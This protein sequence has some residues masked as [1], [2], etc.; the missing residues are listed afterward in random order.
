MESISIPISVLQELNSY[1]SNDNNCCFE[2]TCILLYYHHSPLSTRWSNTNATSANDHYCDNHSNQ[3]SL[4]IILYNIIPF[5]EDKADSSNSIKSRTF[6]NTQQQQGEVVEDLPVVQLHPLLEEFMIVS[7]NNINHKNHTVQNNA[8]PSSSSSQSSKAIPVSLQFIHPPN[9]YKCHYDHDEI[10][11]NNNNNYDDDDELLNC[12]ISKQ[13]FYVQSVPSTSIHNLTTA[14]SA[15][16]DNGAIIYNI[17]MILEFIYCSNELYEQYFI[18]MG[19]MSMMSTNMND[20]YHWKNQENEQRM[21][22]TTQN[23]KMFQ[24]LYQILCQAF[25]YRIVKEEMIVP[26]ILPPFP[27]NLGS[28]ID[29]HNEEEEDDDTN[30]IVAFFRLQSLMIQQQQQQIDQSLTMVSQEDYNKNDFYRIGSTISSN[31]LEYYDNNDDDE[32]LHNLSNMNHISIQIKLPPCHEKHKSNDDIDILSHDFNNGRKMI[33]NDVT[34]SIS[35]TCPGYEKLV[36]DIFSMAN[37]KVESGAPTGILLT[38]CS[39]VGKTTLV[40]RLRNGSITRFGNL[41]NEYYIFCDDHQLICTHSFF[42]L[43]LYLFYYTHFLFFLFGKI[44]INCCSNITK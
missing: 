12:T 6:D 29:I 9:F 30:D 35:S 44:G 23:Q 14:R 37:I 5:W 1:N 20:I 16:T 18:E 40:R 10:Y 25:E 24:Y 36:N 19:N 41:M 43:I 4:F 32:R 3:K 31:Q 22:T 13:K 27:Q 8:N 15:N 34:T 21:T 26:I 38:G 39:G 33:M 42:F 11:K 17:Q 28:N 2:P 7:A